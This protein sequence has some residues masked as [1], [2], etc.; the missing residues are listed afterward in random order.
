MPN[1]QR[2]VAFLVGSPGDLINLVSIASVF[3][4]PKVEGK[5]VYLIEL[6]SK[7]PVHEVQ[8]FGGLTLSNCTPY[9]E[10][11]GPI[12]ILV[13]IGGDSAFRSPSSELVRWMRKKATQVRCLVSVCTG[14]FTLAYAGLL[15]G[16][17]V[18]THW[19]HAAKLAQLYPRLKVEKDR[20][21]L[22]DGKVY[23]TAGVTAGIDMALSIVEE[24]LGHAEAAKIAHTLV[25]YLRRS[26][27]ESQY[28]T[29]L[30]QQADVSGTPMRDLPAWVKS[31]LT[32]RLDVHTLAR[33][34]A[35]TPRTFARQFEIHFKTTPA[36]WVQ[37]LRIEAACTH[38]STEEIPLKVIAKLTGFRDEQS[39]RRAFIQQLKITPKEYRERFGMSRF[40]GLPASIAV[41]PSDIAPSVVQ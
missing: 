29:L 30:A 39:L 12:D 1:R 13:V 25:L 15:D 6:L 31:R 41:M 26:S 4:Y 7:E 38:L 22:K 20:I 35:M 9:S 19:H 17:K 11:T 24:D 21:F 37:S 8:G 18:T 36:R 33:T 14:A 3:S 32:Q 34:V 5:P 27:S 2:V 28:S 40:S 23:S 16:K 10:Y